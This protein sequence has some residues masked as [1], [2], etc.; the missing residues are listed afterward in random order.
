MSAQ[1]REKI[2]VDAFQAMCRKFYPDLSDEEIDAKRMHD[3]SYM[4]IYKHCQKKGLLR[5]TLGKR[6][7]REHREAETP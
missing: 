1:E 2:F 5:R 7:D 4:T 3:K 6:K